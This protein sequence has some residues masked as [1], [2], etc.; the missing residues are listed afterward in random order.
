MNPL[1]DASGAELRGLLGRIEAQIEA[2]RTQCGTDAQGRLEVLEFEAELV[3]RGTR[4]HHRCRKTS[5]TLAISLIV[6][7]PSRRLGQTH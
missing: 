3:R 1:R 2:L 4:A 5:R 7:G 6:G